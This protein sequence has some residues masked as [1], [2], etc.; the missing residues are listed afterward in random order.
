[1]LFLDA[2]EVVDSEAFSSWVKT[3]DLDAVDA[4]KFLNYW[5]F[6][7]V[8]VRADAVEDSVVLTRKLKLSPKILFQSSER[9]ALKVGAYLDKATGL[10]GDPMIHHYSWVRTKKEM[11]QKV[12]NWGHRH[13]R[14][15]EDIIESEF[16]TDAIPSKDF[17]HGYTLKQVSPFITLPVPLTREL[18]S[19]QSGEILRNDFPNVIF[20][21]DKQFRYYLSRINWMERF[22]YR[23]GL[24]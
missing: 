13:D 20:V 12:K 3:V 7:D 14:N 21:S 5:Y 10:N 4:V 6:K 2:D 22:R 1:M 16:N 24:N 23:F 11:I 18:P 15:W 19:N 17:V 9:H 8:N